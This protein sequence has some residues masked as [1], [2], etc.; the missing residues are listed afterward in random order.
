MFGFRE[1]GSGTGWGAYF[2]VTPRLPLQTEVARNR[3]TLVLRDV[4]S[5]KVLS[6]SDC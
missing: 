1:D 2:R 3:Y 5:N 6:D 4:N